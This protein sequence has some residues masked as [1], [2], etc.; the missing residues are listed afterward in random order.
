MSVYSTFYMA[1]Q[2]SLIIHSQSNSFAQLCV[3]INDE[4]I[5]QSNYGQGIFIM[6]D[7]KRQLTVVSKSLYKHTYY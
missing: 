6:Q 2:V 7:T 1:W 3:D 4:L 5:Q